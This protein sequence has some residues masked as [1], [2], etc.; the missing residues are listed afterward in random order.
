MRCA[1]VTC[2]FVLLFVTGGCAQTADLTTDYQAIAIGV[3]DYAH[4]PDRVLAGAEEETT[5][6]F[7][8]FGVHLIWAHCFD[9]GSV[10]PCRPLL[11]PG[12]ITLNL[13]GRSMGSRIAL[14]DRKLGVTLE[15]SIYILYEPIQDTIGDKDPERCQILARVIAHELGHVFLPPKAHSDK[16]IMRPRWRLRDLENDIS[17][18]RREESQIRAAVMALEAQE[19]RRR[20][21]LHTGTL[22][23]QRLAKVDQQSEP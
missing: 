22:N 21:S 9:R 2:W 15:K 1:V 20:M 17:F 6:M 19:A 11:G 7:G 4:V 16:G 12:F 14:N 18:T 13:V 23:E 8:R 3:Y 5:S 10:S